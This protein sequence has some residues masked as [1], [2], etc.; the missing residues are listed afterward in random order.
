MTRK[1]QEAL[2]ELRKAHEKHPGSARDIHARTAWAL[3]RLALVTIDGAAAGRK[4]Y[5]G[6]YLSCYLAP[7]GLPLHEQNDKPQS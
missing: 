7:Q 3:S 4:V 2:T 1:M 5:N 6:N